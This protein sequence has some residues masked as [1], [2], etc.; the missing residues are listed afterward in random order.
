M[1]SGARPGRGFDGERRVAWEGS[2]PYRD[3]ASARRPAG[4]GGSGRENREEKVRWGG[5]V[6]GF[7]F[8]LKEESVGAEFFSQK[9]G[10]R[11]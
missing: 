1:A 6:M 2:D 7:F 5:P 11:E 10:I 4:V 8:S 3:L 9:F